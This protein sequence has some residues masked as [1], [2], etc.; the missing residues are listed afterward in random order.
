MGERLGG[1]NVTMARRIEESTPRYPLRFVVAGDSGAWPD[2]T[3]A[4]IYRQLIR[5]VA[6]L[7]PAPAFFVNLGDFAGPGTLARHEDY[8]DSVSPLRI[9]NICVI[10][11]HDLDDAAGLETFTRV[12][13]PT[14]YSFRCGH[15]R[16][17]AL[18]AEP[19][20]VGEIDVPGL[21][22][23][24][25]TKGPDPED[26]EFLDAALNSAEEEHRVVLMHMPPWL[27]GHYAPHDAWGFKQAEQEFLDILQRH[28]VRLVC[29]AHGLHFDNHVFQGIRFVM[30][31]GGGSGLCSHWRGICAA[32]PGRPENRG[33]L[34]HATEIAIDRDGSISG[35]V[36]QAFAPTDHPAPYA[37]DESGE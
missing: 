9:P 32:G 25:G 1:R 3:A 20:I 2:P 34:F 10:G 29:C 18:H 4:A 27:E 19:G 7:D 33:A 8:L 6:A 16:F 12:H 5:Q 35:R 24:E 36:L 14:N 21:E 17:I 22:D 23:P 37:F 28:S 13:G 31:G 30:S 15:T 26:L 11:N